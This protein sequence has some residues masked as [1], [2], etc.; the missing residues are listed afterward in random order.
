MNK[1]KR[2]EYPIII[3]RLSTA[4]K[5]VSKVYKDIMENKFCLQIEQFN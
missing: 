5:L 3:K 1:D 4:I 2:M